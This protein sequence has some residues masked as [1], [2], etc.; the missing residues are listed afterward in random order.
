MIMETKLKELFESIVDINEVNRSA[1]LLQTESS[2]FQIINGDLLINHEAWSSLRT[3]KNSV[4]KPKEGSVFSHRNFLSHRL[5][6]EMLSNKTIATQFFILY[7]NQSFIGL[8][9]ALG[10]DTVMNKNNK[11][12]VT[13]DYIPELY[14]V[15]M[16]TIINI[17]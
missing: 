15:E 6:N 5:I 2:V 11:I 7:L 9:H 4:K 8:T 3:V 16:S 14:C 12:N 17:E 13:F 1:V 10:S